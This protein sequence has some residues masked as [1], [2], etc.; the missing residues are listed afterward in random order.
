MRNMGDIVKS[1]KKSSKDTS[2]AM[3]PVQVIFGEVTS[4]SP[5]KIL[6]EQRLALD[7][8]FFILTRSVRDYEIDMTVDSVRKEYTIHNG[9]VVGDKVKLLRV[10]GG[11]QYVVFDKE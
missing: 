3:D 11:Q 8:D 1:I 4:V 10:Q 6:I 9:L 7:E 2:V 5:L